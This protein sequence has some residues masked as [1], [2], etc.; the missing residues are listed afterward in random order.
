[1][2]FQNYENNILKISIF[3]LYTTKVYSVN[4]FKKHLSL[5]AF[6]IKCAWAY[7]NLYYENRNYFLICP[8]SSYFVLI[9]QCQV[10][11]IKSSKEMYI[12]T[13][14]YKN[15]HNSFNPSYWVLVYAFSPFF[16]PFLFFYNKRQGESLIFG[17]H[18]FSR[19]I[20]SFFGFF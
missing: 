18:L 6:S 16:W 4:C 11:T 2:I 12:L 13:C 20:T 8:P 9:K 10:N 5:L 14:L 15:L 19:G 17:L 7:F 1:M 3:V